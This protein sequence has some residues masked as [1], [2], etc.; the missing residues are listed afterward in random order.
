MNKP[1][2]LTLSILISSFIFGCAGPAVR[3]KD[4]GVLWRAEGRSGIC[5]KKPENTMPPS[6]I[7]ERTPNESINEKVT[8]DWRIE[9]LVNNNRNGKLRIYYKIYNGSANTIYVLD[10]YVDRL[11][12]LIPMMN[13]QN[14]TEEGTVELIKG[15]VYPD[16]KPAQLSIPEV[17][18]VLS[19]NSHEGHAEIPL[20]LR[21]VWNHSGGW[22][23]EPLFKQIRGLQISISYFS[24]TG[25]AIPW[26]YSS[27]INGIMRKMAPMYYISDHEKWLCTS[28]VHWSPET[29]AVD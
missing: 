16:G 25:K 22:G 12:K 3:N 8:F 27:T 21:H 13:I 17:N 15:F 26:V 28:T 14:S 24:D 23:M 9:H 10:R 11:G 2:G 20:P 7:S 5:G 29:N 19:G 18:I 6:G 4:L 1:P